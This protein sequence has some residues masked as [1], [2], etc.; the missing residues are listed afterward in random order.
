[1]GEQEGHLKMQGEA[2]HGRR[3]QGCVSLR[4]TYVWQHQEMRCSPK[5]KAKKVLTPNTPN[6]HMGVN[7]LNPNIIINMWVKWL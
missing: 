7:V 6:F 4:L 5:Q 1:M 3:K 2:W